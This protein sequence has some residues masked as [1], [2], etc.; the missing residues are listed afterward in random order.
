MHV[1]VQPGDRAATCRALMRPVDLHYERGE[2][3]IVHVCSACGRRWRNRANPDD[4]LS[5]LIG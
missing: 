5:A 1:D 3:V 2:F 4:D